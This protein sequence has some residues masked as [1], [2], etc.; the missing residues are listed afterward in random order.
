MWHFADHGLTVFCASYAVCIVNAILPEHGSPTQNRTK[1][2]KRGTTHRIMVGDKVSNNLM[3][4][5]TT[6]L[7]A[8]RQDIATTIPTPISLSKPLIL[9]RV[10]L[11]MRIS[12]P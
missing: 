10:N 8:A 7:E 12:E 5:G 6:I 2:H 3:A 9:Q 4:Q 1:Y 11:L